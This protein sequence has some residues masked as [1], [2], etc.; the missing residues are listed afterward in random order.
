MRLST[1]TAPAAL[2][3]LTCAFAHAGVVEIMPPGDKLRKDHPRLLVRAEADPHAISIEQLKA[4]KR[5]ADYDA[6]IRMLKRRNNAASMAMLWM[7]TGDEAAAD[8]AF[9]RLEKFD[10]GAAD[11]FDV[12]FGLRELALAYDWLYNHPKFTPELKKKVRDKAFVFCDKWGIPK[13]DDH[14]FHNYTWMNNCGMALWAMACYGDDPR[15]EKLMDTV[16]L[17]LNGRMF[18]AMEHLNG[19]AGDAMG[20][21]FIYCPATCIWALM[22]VQSAYGI[23]A[24]TPIRE[25]QDD[26]LDR[27][28]EGSIHGAMPNLRFFPW[29]D[30][31]S[32]PD[33]GVTH[34]WAGLADAVTWATKNPQGA[35]FRDWL[36][37][38]R[39]MNRF[40]GETGKLYFLY[41]RHITAQPKVPP[42]AMLAGREH[43]AQAMMRSSWKDD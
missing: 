43:S 40:H 17:R 23:D 1:I 33:G 41:T 6:G 25:K 24:I 30:I 27:Q 35:F 26:W 34:E 5:D 14:V 8:R 13:G 15:A 10:R 42:L 7:L 20:Y 28:L 9:A 16:R 29:G 21:W 3:L 39:G 22:A 37:E 36:A 11:A 38:K 12:F 18:P 32:G 19:M 2:L 4:L 31:Q